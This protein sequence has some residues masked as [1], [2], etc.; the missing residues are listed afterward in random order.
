MYK[1]IETY[2]S[3]SK[4]LLEVTMGIIKRVISK[5][6]KM[7]NIYISKLKLL[8]SYLPHNALSIIDR[9]KRSYHVVMITL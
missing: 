2:L 9:I 6:L 3:S 8:S 4:T 1:K 7:S 5:K